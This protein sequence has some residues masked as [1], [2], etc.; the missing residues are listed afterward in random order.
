MKRKK[1]YVFALIA[2]WDE[3]EK[4]KEDVE[5]EKAFI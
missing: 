4:S 3:D 5:K 2:L 1:D